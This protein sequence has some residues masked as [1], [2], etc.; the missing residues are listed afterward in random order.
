[1]SGRV[2][3]NF[4]VVVAT[5]TARPVVV[6]VGFLVLLPADPA[7]VA[8]RHAVDVASLLLCVLLVGIRVGER[9]GSRSVGRLRLGDL[10]RIVE[11]VLAA[12]D[13][14]ERPRHLRVDGRRD[15]N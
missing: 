15:G 5:G 14:L 4:V 12:E 3:V 11:R 8:R 9:H 2:D 1:M 7:A 10:V 6:D 13:E